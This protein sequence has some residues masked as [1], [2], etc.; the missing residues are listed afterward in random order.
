MITTIMDKDGVTQTTTRGILHTFV[1]FLQS[2][3][4]LIHVDDACVTQMENA[5]HRTLS[6]GWRHLLDMPITAEELKTAVYKGAGNKAPGRDGISL[7]FFQVNWDRI[8]N[9]ACD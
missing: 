6:T 5:E 2:K 9:L 8:K 3:Y 4:D 1:A 7:E